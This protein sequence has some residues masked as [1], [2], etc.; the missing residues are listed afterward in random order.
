MQACYLRKVLHLNQSKWESMV[1]ANDLS[2]SVLKEWFKLLEDCKKRA[3]GDLSLLNEH[4]LELGWA[5]KNILLSKQEQAR[6]SF[7]ED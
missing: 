7:V 2:D 5:V 4:M 1:E 6:Y 3:Q